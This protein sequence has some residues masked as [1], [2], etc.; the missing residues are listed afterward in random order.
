MKNIR[1][2]KL[3][4]AIL[5]VLAV[6][7]VVAIWGSGPIQPVAVGVV[8]VVLLILGGEGLA[9]PSPLNG[10]E[11]MD[12]EAARKRE[13]LSRRAKKRRFDDAP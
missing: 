5:T 12:A 9:G 4:I 6:A 2:T 11:A 1:V 13:V 7:L 8:A 3:G 10:G